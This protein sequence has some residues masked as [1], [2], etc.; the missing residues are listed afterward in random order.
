MVVIVTYKTHLTHIFFEQNQFYFNVFS[1]RSNTITQHLSYVYLFASIHECVPYSFAW[2]MSMCDLFSCVDCTRRKTINKY[3]K[4]IE[5]ARV[6]D[7]Y[8]R[9]Y[10]T[11]HTI[12]WVYI[13]RLIFV[14]FSAHS[15]SSFVNGDEM[16]QHKW[17]CRFCKCSNIYS[18]VRISQRCVRNEQTK[19]IN[20]T[21]SK[22]I[23]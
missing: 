13:T 5:F 12:E 10:N 4:L 3:C 8:W 23:A 15:S 2:R 16:D 19:P 14:L 22:E 21:F 20:E 9:I 17:N 1:L 7:G 6:F 11:L 18:V